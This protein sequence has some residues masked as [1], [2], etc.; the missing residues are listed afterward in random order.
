M[1][2]R[3]PALPSPVAATPLDRAFK[4]LLLVVSL[5]TLLTGAVMFLLPVR[6]GGEWWPWQLTP[7]VSRYFGSLFIAVGVGAAFAARQQ[8]WEQIRAMVLPGV[9]FTG[10]A[11]ISAFLHFDRFNLQRL[12]T[13]LYFGLY[14]FVFLAAVILSVLHEQRA[15]RGG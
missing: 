5:L 13:W 15:R 8:W 2:F 14:I 9:L 1:A 11:L 12:V 6:A 10:M 4:G 3:T 7:L